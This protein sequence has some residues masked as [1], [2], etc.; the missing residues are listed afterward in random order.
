[1]CEESGK[2]LSKPG[3]SFIT[4]WH[5]I[6]G[7]DVLISAHNFSTQNAPDLKELLHSWNALWEE[8]FA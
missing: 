5:E 6:L 1:M 4:Y 2:L 8:I 7:V 3:S